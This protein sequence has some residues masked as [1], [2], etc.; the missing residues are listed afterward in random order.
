MK[1]I[2]IHFGLHKTGTTSIQY[3]LQNDKKKLEESNLKFY[4]GKYFESNHIEFAISTLRSSLDAPIKSRYEFE[5]RNKIHEELKNEI[6]NQLQN[7]V[8]LI[9]SNETLSFIRNQEEIDR[10]KLIFPK[11]SEVIPIIILRDKAEWFI[12]FKRQM[13]KMGG[14][15]SKNQDSCY[16]FGDDSWLLEHERLVELLELNFNHV[17]K[18]RYSRNMVE[19]FYDLLNIPFSPGCEKRVNI[20]D[21]RLKTWLRKMKYNIKQ[22]Y[23]NE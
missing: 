22:N 8:N 15:E 9:I 18:E 14:K 2:Y 10:L 6:E 23:R 3:Q 5:D 20:S 12:S 11:N 13:L 17:L 21:S 7:D 19:S 16:Y 4:S 1:K